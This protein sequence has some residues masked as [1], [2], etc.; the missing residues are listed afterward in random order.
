MG[1][2]VNI[3]AN[4]AQLEKSLAELQ[5]DLIAFREK[6]KTATDPRAIVQLNAEIAKT[7][8]L[9]RSITGARGIDDLNRSFRNIA[10]GANQAANALTNVGRVAQDLPFGFVGIQNNLNPLLESFQRLKAETGSGKEALKA[11]GQSLIGPAGLGIA[12]SVVSAAFVIYQNGISGFNTKTKEA[13][14]KTEEFLKTLKSVGEVTAA[15]TGSQAGDISQVQALAGVITDTTNAYSLR[16][17]ALEELKE[18]NK[19]YFGDLKLE[20]S[21]MTTL[22]DRVNEYTQAIVAQAVVKGFTDEISRVSVE[23]AKQERIL[24]INTNEVNR[25][26]T[27]LDNT[28]K[29]ETSLTGEDRISRKYINTKNA[30][31]DANNAFANQN[32]VVGK[33]RSNMDDLQGSIDGAVKET[34]KFRDLNSP[35]KQKAENDGLAKQLSLLEKIR[36]AQKEFQDKL[37]NLNDIDAAT[38]KLAVLE[39]QVGNLKLKIALRD[40][41]KTGLPAAEIAKLTDA[42]KEDTQKRLNEAF[43]KEAL[44]L[45]FNPK[46]KLSKIDRFD[47]TEI[48]GHSFT[49]KQK[50]K[51]VLDGENLK[52]EVKDIPVDVTDLQ[53]RI[54]KASGFDKKIPTITIPE[55]RIKFE[56]AGLKFDKPADLINAIEAAATEFGKQARQII[57]D[58]IVPAFTSIGE[59]IGEG[60]DKGDIVGGIKK[61][62]ESLLHVIGQV[63]KDIGIQTI[64]AS[65]L[66]IT[67]QKL[68]ASAGFGPGSLAAGVAL[69]AIGTAISNIKFNTPKFAKGGIVSGPIIGQIGEMHRPEVIMPLDRL[70]QMLRSIGGD[71][72]SDLQLI[73]IINNEGL[74]LAVQKGARRAGRKF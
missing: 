11:L 61:A 33:L 26:R 29:S 57:S 54:A 51:V 17:R 14:D 47:T 71:G 46:L 64:K 23:L 24:K 21:Q 15:A 60:I 50:L 41:K 56:K 25:L 1:F 8:T 68:L 38:D 63:I 30:L 3:G 42:I 44:L 20:E 36:D 49:T 31:D 2:S 39:Q 28:S 48:A 59:G 4:T 72:G 6:L 69:V 66:V 32:V 18:V 73:P 19:N 10:P 12:L 67:L 7:N 58:A 9:I 5:A 16:K 70:P 40:A 53:G 35:G 34:L 55:A 62:G 27:A 43:E 52:F 65:T 22:T 37:F 74:Y 13:K 45:E